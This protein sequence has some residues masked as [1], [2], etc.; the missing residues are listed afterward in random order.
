MSKFVCHKSTRLGEKYYEADHRSGLKILIFPKKFN[1]CYAIIGTRFGSADE[2]FRVN[3]REIRLPDGTAHFLEHKLFE[4]ADG[5]NS[6]E[7]FSAMGAET[8]AYTTYSATRYL[9]SATRRYTDCLAELLRFVT[10][11]YFTE[12]NVAKEQGIIKQEIMMYADDP[13]EK[14]MENCLRAMYRRNGVRKSICGTA[15]SISRITPELL[16]ETY[17]TFYNPHN[18]ILSV[19]GDITPEEVLEVVDRELPEETE[20]LCVEPIDP[21]EPE[22]ACRGYIEKRMRVARPLFFIGVK[23]RVEADGEKRFCRQ[24]AMTVLNNMLFSGTGEFYNRLIETGLIT[25]GFSFGYSSGSSF[26]MN[27][28]AGNTEQPQRVYELIRQKASAAVQGELDRADFERC[29]RSSLAAYFKSFDSSAEIADDVMMTAFCAG[30][31]PFSVP[32]KIEALTFEE[33]SAL[34]GELFREDNWTMSAVLPI[35]EQM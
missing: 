22:S 4:N 25:H 1:T 8:N 2:H 11:P 29:R 30:V 31:D 14:V 16:Y 9:F 12:E 35:E 17:N 23:D 28:F 24:L 27:Y 6:D 32:D 5:V 13:Y 7:R 21:R 26:A 34:A 19:C 10:H 15:S 20:Q 33:T 3:G 18:M